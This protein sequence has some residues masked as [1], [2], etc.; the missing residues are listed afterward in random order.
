MIIGLFFY[1][2]LIAFIVAKLE[3]NIEGKDGWASSLPTWRVKNWFTRLFWGEQPYT[4]YHFWLL[5]LVLAFIH[6]P[7]VVG[8]PWKLS[9]ELAFLAAFLLATVLE[10]FFWFWLNPH[11][12][13]KKLNKVHAHWHIDWIG[14]VPR[15]YVSLLGISGLLIVGSYL[16][17]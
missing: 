12:G 14:K 9:T 8:L 11:F 3:I 15:L 16:L 6:Y 4:G 7:F 13:L 5:M 1:S 10:D 17:K 2:I